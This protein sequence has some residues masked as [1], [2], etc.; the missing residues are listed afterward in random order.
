VTCDSDIEPDDLV[1][2]Y[3]DTKAKLFELERARQ[4]EKK[5]MRLDS[6][7]DTSVEEDDDANLRAKLIRIESDVLFDKFDAEQQWKLRRVVL[8]KELAAKRQLKTQERRAEKEA[9]EEPSDGGVNDEAERIAAEIL[10]QGENDDGDVLA[11]L[12]ANLPTNEVDPS[13]GKTTTVVNGADGIKITIR[14]FGK[15]TGV[16]PLRVLEE[17]CRSRYAPLT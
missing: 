8:E 3:L 10:A 16:S 14:D 4:Q 5:K 1:P 9:V 6:S 13:T 12:F 2:A 7:Q 15:W 17:A 11:D